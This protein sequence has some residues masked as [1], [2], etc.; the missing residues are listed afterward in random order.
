MA[1]FIDHPSYERITTL[2]QSFVASIAAKQAEFFIANGYYF[3]GLSLVNGEPDGVTDIDANITKKP[4]DC[5]ETWAD[6]DKSLF[7]A[8]LKLP[9]NAKIDVYESSDG[10]GWTLTMDV[11]YNGSHWVYRHHEG[12]E[13]RPGV[14]NEW[15]IQVD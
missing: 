5:I 4:S 10:W 1:E 13:D 8:N 15:H 3:Q 6:F 7:E 2:K 14:Y 12:P 9:F 11:W